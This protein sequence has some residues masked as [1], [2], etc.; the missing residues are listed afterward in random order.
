MFF[1]SKRA[2][3]VIFST[4]ILICPASAIASKIDLD[5]GVYSE[6]VWTDNVDLAA[7]K[8]ESDVYLM[9]NPYVR[10]NHIGRRIKSSFDYQLRAAAYQQ[11]SGMNDLQHLLRGDLGVDLIRDNVFVDFY[12]AQESE[13]VDA[14]KAISFDGFSYGANT[15]NS[16]TGKV[17]PR[18]ILPIVG[19]IGVDFSSSHGKIVYD[20]GIDDILEHQAH[21][22]LGTGARSAGLNWGLSARKQY[23]QIENSHPSEYEQ[24][25]VSTSFPIFSRVLISAKYGEKREVLS[26]S[27]NR[28]WNQGEIWN[29]KIIYAISSKTNVQFGGGNDLYG[30]NVII[31]FQQETKRSKLKLDYSESE[32]T[33]LTAGLIED[34][35]GSNPWELIYIDDIYV[36]KKG[37][38]KWKLAGVRNT[39][40]IFLKREDRYYRNLGTDETLYA[41]NLHWKHRFSGRSDLI[42]NINWWRL[43]GGSES[44]LDDIA[45]YSLKY[46]R[47]IFQNSNWYISGKAGIRDGT[48]TAL[49]YK[50]LIFLIGAELRY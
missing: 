11:H 35:T 12:L 39:I 49:E 24:L 41:A 50:Q 44:R 43:G 42:A 27:N 37:A 9:I 6:I 8:R 10:A 19:D 20:Q 5:A 18:G 17:M 21:V 13:V 23:V 29:G 40:D 1:L 4:A 36:Q 48:Q 34:V 32:V 2:V 47:G 16:Y 30:D 15:A 38:I 45:L 25:D 3:A 46:A 33:T 28:S 7:S 22:S 26:S 31:S 14:N